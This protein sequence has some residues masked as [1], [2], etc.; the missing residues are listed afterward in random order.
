[1]KIDRHGTAT[2]SRGADANGV[3]KLAEERL[4]SSRPPAKADQPSRDLA[5]CASQAGNGG[6]GMEL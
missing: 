1:M 5:S 6:P 2:Y 4:Q 3:L